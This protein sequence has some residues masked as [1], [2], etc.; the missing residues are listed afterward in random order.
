MVSVIVPIY[1]AEKYLNECIS[2]IL[3]QSYKDFELILIDDGSTDKSQNICNEFAKKDLRITV[4]HQGNSG[5]SAARNNGLKNAKGEFVAFVDSDDYVEKN[6]LE[7][8]VKAITTEEADI[9]V[10]GMKIDKQERILSKSSEAKENILLDLQKCGLMYSTF[11]KLYRRNLIHSD[12]T[13]G[14]KFGEDLLFNLEYFKNIKTIAIVSQALCFYRKDNPMSATANFREDKFKDILYLY[15]KTHNFCETIADS[16]IRKKMLRKFNALHV[17]DYLGNLQRLVESK[18][19]S[20]RE[21]YKY[22]KLIL[23]DIDDKK[24][25]K[26]GFYAF[27]SFNKKIIAYFAYKGLINM[28]LISFKMKFIVKKIRMKTK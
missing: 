26:E 16:N 21:N 7:L 5:V 24:F 18:K 10:C 11:N 9:A 28:L 1:N 4:V 2:S 20:Y 12:F 22:F 23:S 17:W 14:L 19:K 3:S 27:T 25:L 8:L 6:W 13:D 15:K